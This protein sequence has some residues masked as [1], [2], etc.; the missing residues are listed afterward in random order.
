MP[1]GGVSASITG[2]RTDPVSRC[3]EIN[4]K[5]YKKIRGDKMKRT[6]RITALVTTLLAVLT[7]AG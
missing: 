2:V 7:P 5:H 6:L 3:S 4:T 1:E